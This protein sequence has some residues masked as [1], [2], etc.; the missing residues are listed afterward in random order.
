MKLSISISTSYLIP[1]QQTLYEKIITF[2]DKK[3]K[4]FFISTNENIFKLLKKEGIVGIELLVSSNTKYEQ[5]VSIKEKL[6]KYGI[7]ILSIHQSLSNKKNISFGEIE[8]ICKIASF[9]ASSVVVLHSKSLNKRLLDIKYVDDLKQLQKKYKITFGI[10]NMGKSPFSSELFVYQENDFASQIKKSKLSITFD[11]SH[12]GQAGG[13]IIQFYLNN[14][15]NIVNIHF[16]DY[17]K[18]W[19]NQYFISQA[20][21]HLSLGSGELPIEKFLL[22]L[23]K[24]NYKG[25]ITIEVNE[26]LSQILK[27]ARII[28][29]FWA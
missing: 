8:N 19:I 13:D 14:K 18:N 3:A 6:N 25:L 5:I 11:I 17:K 12:L 15:N 2:F 27:S 10:E 29:K 4:S 7:P 1:I 26:E 21:T 20:N 16:S 9:C 23:R 24:T 28:N 22:I